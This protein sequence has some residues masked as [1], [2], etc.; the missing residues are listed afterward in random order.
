MIGE[1]APLFVVDG[2]PVTGG[3]EYLNPSDI[4]SM[5]I[6]KD[7]SATAIY[8]ARGANG[9]VL[10]TT[11]QGKKGQEGRIE[12]NS[13]YGIQKE[14]GRYEVLNA[15]QYAIVANE[16]LKNEGIEPYFDPNAVE[17]VTDWQ[18]VVF[19]PAPIQNHSITVSGGGDRTAYSLS[20]SYFGQEGIIFNS[21]AK[22]GN[23]RLNL[24]HNVNERLDFGMNMTLGRNEQFYVPVDNEGYWNMCGMWAAPP[25]LPVYDED[26][27]PTRIERAYHFA[28]EDMRN[29]V[30]F[31][32][33]R[34]DRTMYDN[35]L[36]NVSLDFMIIE[37]LTFR[38][39]VG[40]EY[41]HG[42]NE[43]FSPVIFPDDRGSASDGY[44]Y[45]NSFLNENTLSYTK[46]FDNHKLDV[47]GG[48]TYQS[49][50][51]RS[52][53]ISVSQIATNITENFD[54]SSAEIIST[55]SNGISEWYLLSGLGRINYSY[56][57]RYLVTASMRADGSSRFGA[58]NKWGYFP[59]GALG[60]RVSDEPFMGN[61]NF[62]NELKLRAS[63]GITGNT[64]LSPY[65]SLSRLR[66]LRAVFVNNTETVGYVPANVANPDL[67][68]ESTAQMDVGLDLGVLQGRLD[69]T[70][71]YYKKVTSDLLASVPI[72]L[73]TGYSSVLK[74]VGKIENH[75]VELSLNANIFTGDFRWDLFTQVST[76][77]NTVKELAGGADILSSSLSHPFNS[78]PN[79]AR[80]DEP[81]GAFYG[82]IED[83]LTDD[84]F[85][86]FVDQNGDGVTNALDR[87]ILG[88]PNPHI[89]YGFNN[90]FSYKNFDLV[91]FFEGV[92][93]QDVFWATAGTH[94]NSFQRG[95]NQFADIFGNYWTEEDPDPN[96]K[97]PKISSVT[98]AQISDRYIKD[99]S[100]LR[101]KVITL[102]YNIPVSRISWLNSAQV[103][104]SGT[105]LLTFTDYP[106]L[107][108]EV[109]TLGND[110]QSVG[111]RLR[112][113]IDQT[114]YP[115][116][117]M[118][119]VG[120]RLSF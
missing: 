4:E 24:N 111:S 102:A 114:A 69:F 80:I 41:R 101:L 52:A 27:L 77:K 29:P 90:N 32:K 6:L 60:W 34:K 109:N 87:V 68:W 81:F 44:S 67:K 89:I 86:K 22:R 14:I 75:G 2:F 117:K 94:L 48:I 38:T 59:S 18:D 57:D 88:D 91:V 51:S 33:P 35:I 37:G 47:V 55:P 97:Y 61:V 31:D 74:N 10:I 19:S 30:I 92:K 12:I 11:K 16:W 66:T 98:N 8:G 106:G 116:A 105:N 79:I 39:R 110:S 70:F 13:Y 54:L 3:I 100:Y 36:G 62:I 42:I 95:H 96:A 108:P 71:D 113:G 83:G 107:D 9:V 5:N 63:Y 7:A 104:V 28:S 119:T 49:Y 1:N 64:A 25:T 76:N 56:K 115:T 85:I 118:V 73:S 21:S 58:E 82:L 103:Y 17:D 72:P 43:F 26:G 46:V 45:R 99:G 15:Y 112:I 78:P 23:L 53:S 40:V 65:Q 50:M 84:G 93:G 120:T 20:G